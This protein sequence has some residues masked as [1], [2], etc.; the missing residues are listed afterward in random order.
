[1]VGKKRIISNMRLSYLKK[2]LRYDR[3]KSVLYNS[4]RLD[5]S[6]ATLLPFMQG[7]EQ[8]NYLEGV[9]KGTY[10]S[11]KLTP[12]GRKFFKVLQQFFRDMAVN[13]VV[14]SGTDVKESE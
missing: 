14:L 3:S 12:K 11:F 13:G 8:M 4:R 10:K 7:L 2:I 6:Y 1:M 9:K 5:I